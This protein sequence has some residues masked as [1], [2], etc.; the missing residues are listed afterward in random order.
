VTS[1]RGTEVGP[2]IE[3]LG[4]DAALDELQRVVAALEAGGQ[5]L[6]EALAAY[7]R[8]V[9]LQGRLERLLDDADAR[10]RRLVERSGGQLEAVAHSDAPED[11]APGR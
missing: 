3:S 10:I 1:E 4:F 9:A 6:E 8:G 7:E 11:P 2:P 5:P